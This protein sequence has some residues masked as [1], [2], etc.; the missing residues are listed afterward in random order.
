ME[1]EEIISK[2]QKLLNLSYNNSSE[3]EAK[4]ALLKAQE[5]MMKYHIESPDL[6]EDG[7]VAAVFHELGRRR[8]TEFVLMIAVVI[9]ENFRSKTAHNGQRIYFFGFEEDAKA[10]K[11][12]FEY[13]LHFGDVAHDRY[14]GSETITKEDDLNWRYGYIIGLKK[15][16]ESRESYELMVIVPQKVEDMYKSLDITKRVMAGEDDNPTK[17]EGAFS[18]G[19]RRGRE[20]MGTREIEKNLH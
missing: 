15:A 11:T 13:A 19:Y 18:D 14:F 3:E 6:D 4:A 2:I 10:A 9:A 17:I 8:K 7:K 12:A 5:L 1:N 20:S 16:F